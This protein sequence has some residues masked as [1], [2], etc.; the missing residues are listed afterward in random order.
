[1]VSIRCDSSLLT[2]EILR[3]CDKGCTNFETRDYHV[4]ESRVGGGQLC[5]SQTTVLTH[6]GVY[7]HITLT[8]MREERQSLLSTG[9]T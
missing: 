6:P 4:L 8:V 7:V 3:F 1:M 2:K 5:D 9:S